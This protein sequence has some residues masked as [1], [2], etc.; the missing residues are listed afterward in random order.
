LELIVNVLILFLIA[1]C[2]FQD[3]WQAK[4]PWSKQDAEGDGRFEKVRCVICSKINGRDKILDAKDDNLKKHQG[5]KK[6]L[7]DMP[8]MKLKR[9]EWYWDLNSTHKRAERAFAA[10]PTDDIAT[11][12]AA[13]APPKRKEVQMAVIFH[14]LQFGRPMTEYPPMKELLQFLGVPKVKPQ[15]L[16]ISNF[17]FFSHFLL[18]H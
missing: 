5:W 17:S 14:L 7:S 18:Q 6:C 1:W 16:L 9:G 11:M 10:L 2:R 15:P 8:A 12:V 4:Y 13:G 3:T